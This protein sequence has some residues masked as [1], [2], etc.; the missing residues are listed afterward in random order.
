MVR[1]TIN[2]NE[3]N[4]HKIWNETPLTLNNS[5]KVK[6]YKPGNPAWSDFSLDFHSKFGVLDSSLSPDI[7]E[8]S[9]GGI[10]TF[11]ISD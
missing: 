8:N 7:E 10:F 1:N 2:P 6:S 3:L 5:K 11:R 4:N 9:D